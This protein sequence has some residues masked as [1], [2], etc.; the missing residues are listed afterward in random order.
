VY[1]DEQLIQEIRTILESHGWTT[2]LTGIEHTTTLEDRQL[3]TESETLDKY[4][5]TLFPD[6]TATKNN[7]KRYYDGK[8][9]MNRNSLFYPETLGLV[10]AI[11]R[12]MYDGEQT[13]Y[14][15]KLGEVIKVMLTSDF[16]ILQQTQKLWFRPQYHTLDPSGWK[17]I[18]EYRHMFNIKNP[19]V[20]LD[21]DRGNNG[22]VSADLCNVIPISILSNLPTLEQHLQTNELIQRI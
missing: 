20:D 1:S 18:K 19:E 7:V 10:F 14:C 22:N 9:P 21:N 11:E 15:V 16:K 2:K 3:L 8:Q 6:I 4:R 12:E 17:L 5:R 13:F